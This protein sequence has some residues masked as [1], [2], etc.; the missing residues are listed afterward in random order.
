M[1]KRI[2]KAFSKKQKTILA[3]KTDNVDYNPVWLEPNQNPFGI[4]VLDV[5]KYC[6]SMICWTTDKK[7]A[8][9]FNK[10]RNSIG[11]KYIGKQPDNSIG[12]ECN[13]HYSHP[14]SGPDGPIFKATEMEDKWDI[15][16]HNNFLYFARSWSGDLIFLTKVEFT[17]KEVVI[18]H[19]SANSDFVN[20]DKLNAISQVDYIIKSH[21]FKVEVPHSLPTNFQGNNT[22]IA[23][24]SFSTYGRRASFATYEDTVQLKI[25]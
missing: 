17:G 13:L 9:K 18:G 24:Y 2:V 11:E 14:G 3:G 6:Q 12:I 8:K 5:R 25:T 19:I 21:L 20:S 15:Y 23:E 10:L 7:V 22:E 4:K 1:I 16:I